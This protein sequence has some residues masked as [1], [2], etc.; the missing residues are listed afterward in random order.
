MKTLG[1]DIGTTTISAVVVEEN[2][3]LDS[4]TLPNGT[5]LQTEHAWEKL[6][7][8][9]QILTVAL[10]AVAALLAAHPD[11]E[12]IGV[13]GQMHGILYLDGQGVP[14]SPLYTWQDGRGEQVCQEGATYAR[15]LSWQTG[16]PLSTGFGFVTHF[17]NLKNALVP[18]TAKVFCTIQDYIAMVLAGKKEPATEASDAASFGLFRV[19]AGVYDEAALE[20]AGMDATMVPPLAK[21]ACIGFYEGKIHVCVAIGDNQASFLGVTSG[22]T[23]C[24]LL[25]VGTGGQF[26]VFTEKFLECPG[27]ETRPFPGGGYLLVGSSLCSGRAYALLERF[28]RD[29]V[30]SITGQAPDSCYDALDRILVSEEMPDNLPCTL[31]LFQGTRENP[32]LRGSITG[33]DTE[34]FTLRHLTWSMLAGMAKELHDL[35]SHYKRQGGKPMRLMGSGNG[36]RKNVHLQACCSRMF[37]QPLF[38]SDCRE[39]AAVGAAIYARQAVK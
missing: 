35:Y 1:L 30:T 27:L 6:Q 32:D 23:D 24:M 25:N 2:H 17:Y 26:S 31:P 39:E 38:L 11:V 34:N 28:A 7:N 36:L 3:V 21:D 14:V 4:V 19:E 20:R 12:G 5:F 22:D 18:E 13:T 9:K 29:A 37:G 8:P 16:Y 33:L 15:F 10:D